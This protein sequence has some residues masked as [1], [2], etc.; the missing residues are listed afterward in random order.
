M[1]GSTGGAA[2]AAPNP[3]SD[4]SWALVG[5][6]IRTP[7]GAYLVEADVGWDDTEPHSVHQATRGQADARRWLRRQVE[8]PIW[9]HQQ[10][11]RLWFAYAKRKESR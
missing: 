2:T 11:P 1:T 4:D 5:S 8:A 3:Y 10:T 9:Y 6:I 7:Y